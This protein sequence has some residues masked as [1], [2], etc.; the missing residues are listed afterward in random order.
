MAGVPVTIVG[1][2]Y[3][4][5]LGIGGGPVIPPAPPGVVSPPIYYPPV[6]SEPPGP[7]PTHPIHLPPA[8]PPVIWPPAGVVSPPIYYPPEI[9]GPPGP[10]PQP[11]FHPGG[12]PLGIWGGGNVPMPTPPIYL[13]PGT[14]PGLKPEHPIYIPPSGGVPGVPAHPIVLPPPGS[15]PD[16]KPEVLENWDVKTYWLP[17]TGWGVAIVPS[18]EHPGTP[19]PSA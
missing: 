19:T 12:P 13:P 3:Y 4:S 11:P 2:L 7:W 6:I 1:E 17:T 14:I 8:Q 10:W 5:S 18:T 15:P 9:S 16:Q